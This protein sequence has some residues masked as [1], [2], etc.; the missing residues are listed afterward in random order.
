MVYYGQAGTLTL[1]SI[2]R[3]QEMLEE[4]I[5]AAVRILKD[6]GLVAIPTDTLYGLAASP[7]SK[8][9]IESIFAL[10]G[11]PTQHAI[12]LLISE[13]SDLTQWTKNI[14]QIT[15]DLAEQFWPGAL[16]LVLKKADIIPE[17]VS[18][19]MDTIAL[20]VPDHQVT[21]NIIQRL[22]TP[23]TGTSAN[24][25]GKPGL[26]T[27]KSVREEFRNEIDLVVDQGDTCPGIASTVLDIS[28]NR[29]HILRQGAVPEHEIY[30]VCKTKL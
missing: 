27:G 19:G 12:P 8:K 10:K 21:R 25:S 13:S 26:Y 30:R 5:E 24:R 2:S 1:M 20:R 9:A 14:P 15:W 17:T 16:T 11:R 23:I 3:P 7:F 4:Q 28:G 29:P 18:G 22:G 6:D